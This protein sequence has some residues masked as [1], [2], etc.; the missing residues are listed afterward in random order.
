M[1]DNAPKPDTSAGG[2]EGLLNRELG[3]RDAAPR[4]STLRLQPTVLPPPPANS[5]SG[6]WAAH[7][8]TSDDD[9]DIGLD[10]EFNAK[11]RQLIL[12]AAGVAIAAAGGLVW[13]LVGRPI[14]TPPAIEAPIAAPAI[15]RFDEGGGSRT[16]PPEAVVERP[17]GPAVRQPAQ[18]SA[19]FALETGASDLIPPSTEGLSPARRVNAVRIIMDGD[20]EIRP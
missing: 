4:Y 2:L 19:E 17:R 9:I 10:D 12:A 16:A 15:P 5:E 13:L 20:R 7:G 3:A 14:N 6:G 11:R 18:P 1:G 8:A